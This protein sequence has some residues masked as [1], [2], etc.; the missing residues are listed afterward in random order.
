M[1]SKG[2]DIYRNVESRRPSRSYVARRNQGGDP[3]RNGESASQST[4]CDMQIPNDAYYAEVIQYVDNYI[5]EIEDSP[6]LATPNYG[7]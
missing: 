2:T 1:N 4:L 6:P 3:N 5:W 7:E